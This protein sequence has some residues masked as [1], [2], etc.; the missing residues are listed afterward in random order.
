MNY[1]C[2]APDIGTKSFSSMIIRRDVTSRQREGGWPR[3]APAIELWPPWPSLEAEAKS[4][5]RCADPLTWRKYWERPLQAA[6]RSIDC[7]YV[8]KVAANKNQP[9]LTHGG[10]SAA[11]GW[12]PLL[13]FIE[14]QIS[15]AATMPARS[16][17]HVSA[18]PNPGAFQGIRMSAARQ[19]LK[20]MRPATTYVESPSIDI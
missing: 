14:R 3:K 15:Q 7:S 6:A 11:S 1:S 2:V 10:G 8:N 12:L 13:P 16:F 20:K 5:P 9:V 18:S 17:G 4:V 19:R